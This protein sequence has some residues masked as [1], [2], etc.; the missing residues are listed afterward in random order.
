MSKNDFQIKHYFSKSII[1][2]ILFT[3]ILVIS[4][5]GTLP[6]YWIG[7]VEQ[8]IFQKESLDAYNTG[9]SLHMPWDIESKVHVRFISTITVT[10]APIIDTYYNI[11]SPH[12]IPESVKFANNFSSI[13]L[14][15]L[16]VTGISFL[17]YN[18]KNKIITGS[19]LIILFWAS[20]IFILLSL[21]T[22][23]YSTSRFFVI[24]FLPIMLISSYGYWKF[25]K[26]LSNK[27]IQIISF[28]LFISAHAITTLVF[29]EE[30]FYKSSIIWSDPLFIK[31]QEAFTHP[32]VLGIGIIFVIFFISVGIK[33]IKFL[34]N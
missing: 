23:S 9:M 7:P 20:S 10:F 22:E 14:S 25:F 34:K 15:I 27:K 13:P 30:I 29:W 2:S 32:E 11:F 21:M 31:S 17:I 12:N 8:I 18:I 1:I 24:M 16:L 19:E 3:G 26:T 28:S 33:K 4:I 5:I 6:F